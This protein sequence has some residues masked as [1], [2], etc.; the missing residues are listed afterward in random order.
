M[1]INS[2]FVRKQLK[3]GIQAHKADDNQTARLHFQK[4]L[5]EDSTNIAALLWLA[6]ITTDFDKQLFLLQRVLQFDPKN[7]RAQRGIKWVEQQKAKEEVSSAKAG[8]TNNDADFAAVSLDT[9]KDRIS[10][11]ELKKKAQKG[12]IAQ[13]A[14]RRVSPLT[15]LLVLG[16]VLIGIGVWR[17]AF[18]KSTVSLAALAPS[19]TPALITQT[20]AAVDPK[21]TSDI[22]AASSSSDALAADPTFTSTPLPTATATPTPANTPVPPA[23]TQTPTLGP[24]TLT[25]TPLAHQPESS[26]EKWIEIDLS[27]QKIVAWEGATPVMNFTVSTG[28]PNTPTV[29]GEFRIYEKLTATRMSGPGYDLPG[30]PHTMYFHGGYALHGAYWHN[31][32]GQP[33]SHGC[34]NLS[35]PDAE[36]LFNWAEPILPE[37]ITYMASTQDAPGTLVVVHQ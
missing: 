19:A 16:L 20:D 8:L 22:V 36:S 1:A 4:A 14:R 13:R 21:S 6:Y 18:L 2:E 25:P 9:L 31:N 26:D 12:I 37:G 5:R 32:F 29:Q 34:V 10:A 7:E 3:Q 30:V 27:D 23:P 24:P 17:L 33:M 35:L 15:L 28:L 11:D